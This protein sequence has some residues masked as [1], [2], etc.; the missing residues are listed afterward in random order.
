VAS[1]DVVIRSNKATGPA[2]PERSSSIPSIHQCVMVED[3]KRGGNKGGSSTG[4]KNWLVIAN[5]FGDSW[6]QCIKNDGV[7]NFQVTK[8]DFIGSSSHVMEQAS[9]SGLK[10]YADNKVGSGY[11]DVGVPVTTGAGPD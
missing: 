11:G 8:N 3:Y 5:V 2:N 9:G 10:F 6:N 1:S 7:D 4:M